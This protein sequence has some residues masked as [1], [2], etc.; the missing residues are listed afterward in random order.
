[1]RILTIYILV[2][3]AHRVKIRPW[4]QP[5]SKNLYNHLWIY[6]DSTRRAIFGYIGH[7]AS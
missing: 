2:S 5:L 7:S 3:Y 4:G 6:S 1:M